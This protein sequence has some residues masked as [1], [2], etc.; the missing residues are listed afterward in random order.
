MFCF[1]LA[2]QS[3]ADVVRAMLNDDQPLD[4]S[5]VAV[6]NDLRPSSR[7][8]SGFWMSFGLLG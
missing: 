2:I 4:P 3:F 6:L 5:P 8:A 1:F 7:L